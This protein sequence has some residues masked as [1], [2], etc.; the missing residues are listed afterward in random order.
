[1]RRIRVKRN[2]NVKINAKTGRLIPSEHAVQ[3]A[4]IDWTK[5]MEARYPELSLL[6]AVPNGGFRSPSVAKTLQLEGV[7]S[8][9]PDLCLPVARSG[10]YGLYME[11]KAADGRLSANQHRWLSNLT[12]QGY[13]AVV[14]YSFDQAREFLVNYLSDRVGSC[15]P[16]DPVI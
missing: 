8:G 11:L 10:Y 15:P 4:L 5:M 12:A 6:Y 16:A 9:V 1:M 13:A 2:R 3:V 7:K 14:A